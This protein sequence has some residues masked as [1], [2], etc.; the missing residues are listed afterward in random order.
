MAQTEKKVRDVGE[1]EWEED[2]E[3]HDDDGKH[4]GEQLFPPTVYT[5]NVMLTMKEGENLQEGL[6]RVP[7]FTADESVISKMA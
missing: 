6:R 2:E 1:C 3:F 4:I 5:V 7:I